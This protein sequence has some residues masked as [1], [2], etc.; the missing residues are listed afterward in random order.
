MKKICKNCENYGEN[1]DEWCDI[2]ECV[3]DEDDPACEDFNA[4]GAPPP[5]YSAAEALLKEMEREDV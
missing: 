5:D 4:E 3:M 1:Y 2:F